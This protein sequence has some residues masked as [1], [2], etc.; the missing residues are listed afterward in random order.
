MIYRFI[1]WYLHRKRLKKG[2]TLREFCKTFDFEPSTISRIER[3]YYFSPAPE[4]WQLLKKSIRLVRGVWRRQED[5]KP[6]KVA[7]F[8]R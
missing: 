7:G 4:Y 3:G 8:G 2:Y 5:T 1:G 6:P